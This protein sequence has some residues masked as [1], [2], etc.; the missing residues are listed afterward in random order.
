[1][2]KNEDI[3]KRFAECYSA[4]NSGELA[5]ILGITHQTINQW[6]SGKKQVPWLRMRTLVRQ[7]LISWDWLL[8]GKGEMLQQFHTVKPFDDDFHIEGINT[9]FLSLF[10][11]SSQVMLAQRLEVSQV[12]IS[13]WVHSIQQVPWEK[14]RYAVDTFHV[15]WNWL[16]DGISV[17][18]ERRNWQPALLHLM[19]IERLSLGNAC[20][21]LGISRDTVLAWG[22]D[23][24]KEHGEP[25]AAPMRRKK[26]ENQLPERHA[27]DTDDHKPFRP[28]LNTREE[29]IPDVIVEPPAIVKWKRKERR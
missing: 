21:R 2:L 28:Q 8:E 23:Y 25:G 29:K 10:T 22:E 11:E 13:K 1:M 18:P 15:S 4:G 7:K 17:Q 12:T 20:R 27:R 24:L 5:R 19:A 9:R 6:K 16:I 26:A 3:Y 14:L